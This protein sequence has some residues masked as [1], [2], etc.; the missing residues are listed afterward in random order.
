MLLLA[1]KDV[2]FWGIKSDTLVFVFAH[3]K[4]SNEISVLLKNKTRTSVE[5]SALVVNVKIC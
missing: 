2:N 4:G 5:V 1:V 3:K